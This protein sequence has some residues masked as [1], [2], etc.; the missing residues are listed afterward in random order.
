MQVRKWIR[1]MAVCLLLFFAM[2]L[3][4]FAETGNAVISAE[5]GFQG[6]CKIGEMNPIKVVLTGQDSEIKGQ[7]LIR[8]HGKIYAH[9]VEL[10]ANTKKSFSFS[11]P[12]MQPNGSLEISIESDGKI[13]EKQN[14]KVEAF[15]RDT[16]F[17]GILTDR[18]ESMNGLREI[19]AL[20]FSEPKIQV[21]PL[22][23]NMDYGPQEMESI[24]FIL[25]DNFY[26]A[27]MPQESQEKLKK[28]VKSGNTMLVGAGQYG[29]KTLT[30]ILEGIDGVH[31]MGQGFVV[32]LPSDLEGQ[33]GTYIKNLLEEWITPIGLSKLMESNI[34][35]RQIQ[36][37]R[38]LYETANQ[39]MNPAYQDLLFWGA[40]LLI[41]LLLIAIAI[42][43]ENKFKSLCAVIIFSFCVLFYGIAL[44]GGIQRT[45]AVSA[46]V[47]LYDGDR[48]E[49]RIT[50]IYPYEHSP[51]TIHQTNA[52][53]MD[54]LDREGI[55][56][57]PVQGEVRLSPKDQPHVF[58]FLQEDLERTNL[59]L[60]IDK[61]GMVKGNLKNPLAQKMD[62]CFLLLGN[63]MIPI[64]LLEGKENV[65][66]CYRLDHDLSNKGDYNYLADIYEKGGLKDEQRQL[67]DYY[68]YQ[69]QDGRDLIKF[70]GF[71]KEEKEI[72]I[73]GHRRATPQISLNVFDVS[74]EKNKDGVIL[75]MGVVQP[76]T[77][78]K[79]LQGNLRKE[80]LLEEG[81]STV[82]YYVLPKGIRINE[83]EL[84][85]KAEAS[86][87]ELEV[88]NQQDRVW[89]VLKERILEEK[90]AA[91]YGKNGLLQLRIKGDGRIIIPQISVKGYE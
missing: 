59:T 62:S 70:F 65:E 16:V 63:T 37:S 76:M 47:A 88:Y 90:E 17:V 69:I 55:F 5:I 26:I 87:V 75:P 23:M 42:F 74:L 61:E 3:E 19:E 82:F 31:R 66:I 79:E 64:G 89:E 50:N 25:V 40:L 9:S 32:V 43:V 36:E 52:F 72:W 81:K 28:W 41:Y 13:I 58:S 2:D 57:N 18:P 54:V 60:G 12:W 33:Q 85:A 14:A 46:G 4:T 30:G 15:P 67:F 48:K 91:V 10:A 51:Y 20:P 24:N 78:K 22:Q 71:S 6:R 34:R 1:L 38:K 56:I 49:Y 84:T 80:L 73:N 7:L 39:L 77:A 68:F 29:Y 44:W 21:I 45:K 83:I 35:Q 11:I 53:S 86:Y 27:G 8:T